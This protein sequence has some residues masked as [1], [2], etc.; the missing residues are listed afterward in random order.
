MRVMFNTLEG[1]DGGRNR[2]TS[3]GPGSAF[4][5]GGCKTGKGIVNEIGIKPH[6]GAESKPTERNKE[7]KRTARKKGREREGSREL[8]R[9]FELS[10]KNVKLKLPLSQ[11]TLIA[12]IA[13]RDIHGL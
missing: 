6:I 2:S 4:R 9:D 5:K 8:S 7:K 10:S 3:E 12:I 13:K 1:N 11:K